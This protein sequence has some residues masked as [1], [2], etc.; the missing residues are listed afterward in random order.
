MSAPRRLTWLVFTTA[1]AVIA[2]DQ[3]SKMLVRSALEGRGPVELIPGV[4][5]FSYVTNTGGAF[6]LSQ[7]TPWFFAGVSILV[8]VWICVKAFGG[9]GS[10]WIALGMGLVLGGAVG[11][12]IDRAAGGLAMTGK[13]T[14]FIDFRVWPVFNLA[15]SAVVVGAAVLA[16]SLARQ[17]D[18][19]RQA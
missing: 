11:N 13:V 16:I 6:G 15:D 9:V 1:A 14:D 3:T 5:R 18:D 10:R 12:V 17:G 2:L 8:S 7:S 19:E 4:L